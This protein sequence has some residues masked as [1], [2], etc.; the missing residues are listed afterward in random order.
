L[1]PERP[2]EAR[3][4]LK[5]A[6]DQAAQAITEGRDAVQALRSSTAV[7][8][9]LALAIN[10]LGQ[11]LASGE[12]NPDAAEFQVEVEGT[13]RDLHP[14]VRDELYRI[15]GEA[16]RNAFK[17]AQAQRIAVQIGYDERQLRLRVRDDGK[18]IDPKYL[19]KDG[20]PGHYGQRGI[21][22]RAKLIGGELTV[23][24]ELD[25]GTVVELRIFASRAY[26]I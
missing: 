1:L 11:E 16:V 19:D 7:T 14:I 25:S 12:T 4:T 9:D 8:N 6:I 22:E 3:K 20:Y 26:E 17:H 15:A 2:E 5:R 21:R 10:S 24:T 13:P 23:W 18:G